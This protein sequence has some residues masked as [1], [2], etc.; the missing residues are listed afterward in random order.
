MFRLSRR[1]N[2]CYTTE[3]TEHLSTKLLVFCYFCQLYIF[4]DVVHLQYVGMAFYDSHK[5]LADIFL[6]LF[7]FKIVSQLRRRTIS[8]TLD[9]L[10]S[11]F[12]RFLPL[13]SPNTLTWSFSLVTLFFHALALELQKAVKLGGI[14]YSIFL[15]SL[16]FSHKSENF[17]FFGNIFSSLS[18][19]WMTKAFASRTCHHF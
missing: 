8:L 13:F 19:L 15:P 12:V 3:D 16:L 7:S 14:F 1:G 17:R 11:C 6:A 18:K 4:C 5:M 9:D 10:F 2:S